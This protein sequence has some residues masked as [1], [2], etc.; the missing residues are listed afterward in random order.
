M[1]SNHYGRVKDL[2]RKIFL[3]TLLLLSFAA[4]PAHAGDV[5][6]KNDSSYYEISTAAQLQWF[7]SQVN[8][9]N[10]SIN[11]VLTADIDLSS[12]EG[13]YWTPIGDGVDDADIV[14]KGVFDGN[15]HVVSGLTVRPSLGSGL[16]G[17]VNG[18]TIRNLVISHPVLSQTS[19]EISRT[20]SF[21]GSLCG[22]AINTTI[23]NCHVSDAVLVPNSNYSGRPLEGVG[24]LCG[25]LSGGKMYKCTA[26]G[27][28]ES[29]GS[30]AGGIAALVHVSQVDSCKLLNTTK[31]VSRVYAK[32]YA[33][34]I[35]GMVRWRSAEV[36]LPGCT[37]DNG[38]V[39]ADDASTSGKIYGYEEFNANQLVTYD[40]YV[41]IY[42]ADHLKTFANW[43]NNGIVGNK[44]RLMRDINMAAA[45]GFTPIGT[46]SKP[47]DGVFDGQGHTIDS[48]TINN[49]DYAG[50]FG[51]VKNGKVK[52]LNLTNPSLTTNDEEYLGFIAGRLTQ[53]SGL[54]STEGIIENCHVTGG[55]LL[56]GGDGEPK[57]VAGI[58]GKTDM[59]AAVSD[60]SFQGIIKAHED[61]IGGI[62]G[63]MNSGSTI[64]RSYLIGPSTVWGNNYVGGI[65]GIMEDTDTKMTDCFADQSSGEITLHAESGNYSGML[66][67]KDN[68]GTSGSNNTYTEE[69]LQYKLT[70]RQ[71]SVEGGTAHETKITGVASSG[72]GTYC[73]IVDIG[74]SKKYFTTEIENVNG[75]EELYFW[76][77]NSNI[78]GTEACGWINMKIDDYAF[79]RNFKRL[80]MVYRIFAGDDHDVMLRPG[81]VRPAGDKMFAN[82]P[83]AKVYVDAEYYD[84]FC[85][86]SVWSKYKKYLV[87]TTSMRRE[88]VNAEYGARYAYDRNRDKTGTIV[89][90]DNGSY[91]GSSQVHV[92]GADD[93]YLNSNDNVLWIYQDIGQTYDFNTTKV[94]A[95]AFNGKDNIQQVK[96]QEITKSA[97]GAS[98]PFHI[99]I[100]DSAFANCKNLTA[101]NI[102][103]YSDEDADHVEFL[104][105]SQIPVGKGVFDNS[106]KAKVMV[107]RD[108]VDEFRYDTQYGWAQYKNIIEA[109]D[110]GNNNYTEDGVIYSYFT[111]EDGQ[112]YYTNANN[113][114]MEKIVAS[115]TNMYANFSPGKVLEYN[116]S[117]TIKYMLASGIDAAKIDKL[118]GVMKLYCDIGETYPNHYKT[119]ALSANGFQYQTS[120]KKIVF[121]DIV[122]NNYN[123]VTDLNFVIPD[124][125][126]RGCS[127]LK[128]LNMFYYVTRGENNYD[129][130]K[131]SQVFIGK[132]VFDGVDK[133]FRIVVMPEYY[134]DYIT[135]PNWSQYKDYIIAADYLPTDAEPVKVEGVTYDY[136]SRSLNTMS[137]SEITRLQNSAWNWLIPG[138]ILASV[139]SGGTFGAVVACTSWLDTFM[140][141]AMVSK[142][143]FMNMT[144][145][146]ASVA[147][148]AVAGATDALTSTAKNYLLNRAQR[149]YSRPATWK[150][151]AT[152]IRTEQTTNVPNMYI[153][154]VDDSKSSIFIFNDPGEYSKDYRTVGIGRTAF[155]NKKN[156]QYIYFQDRYGADSESL[157][158]M[159]LSLP[160][161]CFAGCTNL[162][163]INFVIHSTG[164][165]FTRKNGLTPD[166]FIPYGDIFAGL[167]KSK[168]TIRVSREA[169]PE[170]MADDYWKQYKDMYEVVDVEERQKQDEWKCKY[171]LAFNNNTI[172][173]RTQSQGHDIEHVYIYGPGSGLAKT[174]LAALINDFGEWNNYKLDFVKSKAFYGNSD[175]KTLDITDTHSNIADVYTDFDISL[176]DS[177]FADCKNFEDFNI[178]YQVTDGDNHTE[179]IKPSQITLGNGVF[180]GCDKLRLKFCLDQEEAFLADTTWA[181]YRDKFRPCFFEP[182]DNAVGDILLDSYR[183]ATDLNSASSFGHVDA[184]RANPEDLKTLFRGTNIGTFDEFRAFSSCGLKT[185]YNSMFFGCSSLQS[186]LLPDSITTI[187][188]DAFRGCVQL[189]QLT[190]PA[191][192]TS[193]QA[194]AFA[195][196]GIKEFFVKNPVPADIDAAKAFSDLYESY[197]IYVADSVVDKYKAKW[198]A[199]ADHING[200]GQRRSLKVVTVS[201]PGTLAKEL[202]LSYNYSESIFSDNSLYGNYAQ[203]DSLRVIGTL[204][205]R[206]I[207]VLRYLGG[208]DVDD[209][210]KTPGHL[211]Y[212]DLYEAN[213]TSEGH[214]EYN[215]AYLDNDRPI[216]HSGWSNN[217]IENDNEVSAFMFWGLDQLKTLILPKTATDIKAGAFEHCT[218]LELL[219]IGDDMKKIATKYNQNY[220]ALSTPNKVALVMLG[221]SAPEASE[222]AFFAGTGRHV[223]ILNGSVVDYSEDNSRF[224]LT[225][226]P[227]KS[228]EGY[229]S[230]VPYSS[231]S[232]SIVCNFE[233]DELVKALKV[234]HV[235]S[236]FDLLQ[237]SDITG[238]FN[239]NKGIRKFND[240]YYS[241][242][243][244]LGDNTLTGMAGLTEVSLPVALKKITAKAFDGCTSLQR[245][246]AFGVMIPE[247]E[248]GAFNSLPT[249]FVIMVP[250]GQEDA[251]RKAWPQ[252]KNHIQGYRE[253]T[254]NIR[255]ITLT[256]PN[257]LADSLNAKITMDDNMVI[258]V[259]GDLSNIQAL[260]ISGPIGGKDIAV[261]RYL[262]GREPDWNNIVYVTNLR[263]LDLYDAELRADQYYFMLK[264]INRRIE[265]DN[266]VPKDMFWNCDHLETLILPRTATKLCYEACYDMASLK[267]LVIGDDVTYIDND[268][269]GDNRKLQDIIFLCSSKPELDGDAFTDPLEG[270]KRKVDKIYVRQSLV[271][272][273]SRDDE[274]TSHTNQI[275]NGFGDLEYFRAFGSK[276]IATEDDLP[277]ITCIDGW[278]DNFPGVTSLKMLNKSSI[279]SLGKDGVSK[280]KNLQQI[281]LP[282]TLVRIGDGAFRNSA[283]LHWLD[284][285]DCDSLKSSVDQMEV[286]P[287]A[288]VYIPQSFGESNKANVVFGNEGARQCA[289]YNL[290]DSHDYDVPKAFTAQKVNF[291]REYKKGEY[292][293]LT[294]PFNADKKPSGFTFYGL[295]TDSTSNGRLYFGLS[296]AIEANVPYVV[297]ARRQRT[298]VFNGET[299]IPV[300]PER[301]ISV[302]GNGYTM[303]G[304][305]QTIAANVANEQKIM[306]M[307]DSTRWN[308]V[309]A[310][311]ADLQPFT[312]YIIANS[313]AVSV[314][315]VP[316]EFE[317]MH[318]SVGDNKFDL[319]GD[320]TEEDPFFSHNLDLRDGHD[321]RS[322]TPFY[323]DRARYRRSAKAPWGTLC[324]PY[325]IETASNTDC[326][327]YEIT[328]QS[329]NQVTLAKLTGTIEAG[330]SIVLHM[331]TNADSLEISSVGEEIYVT[332]IPDNAP[333]G[334]MLG[335]FEETMAPRGSYVIADSKFTLADNLASD[336]AKVGAFH[337]YV[338][339]EAIGSTAAELNIVVDDTPSAID[340]LND[341]AGDPSTEYYD[342]EGH[343][344]DGLRKGVN[345]IKNGNRTFKVVIK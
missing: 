54:T 248:E 253:T 111:S 315:N 239:G 9:K 106:A 172:P 136:V 276:A 109:G 219:V 334:I 21:V 5:P 277:G 298:L 210:C 40:G 139:A 183:F 212:L 102:A 296:S 278:F 140:E 124:N 51:Y 237:T 214:Y 17:Y 288:L 120:I 100:G 159:I 271:Y 153:S 325:A 71:L 335:T 131:P 266:E 135:D 196:S 66:C 269:L 174:G 1:D 78:A 242:V 103:L 157:N 98:E 263:Y 123:T 63:E 182:R 88:D 122:A 255:E 74:T 8:G 152:W 209:N 272:Q 216:M 56:R 47:F 181:K 93:S 97:D 82:C 265:N 28:I 168:I 308:V 333:N 113:E 38:K 70:G 79:D 307:D 224:K 84:E 311:S 90:V 137:T 116:N 85:N 193:I 150:M 114:E 256:K 331:L 199:V 45:G 119:I 34:G 312:S 204:D 202:G 18:A 13:D 121:E 231:T 39:S 217:Y 274:F 229:S 336:A 241:A 290:T 46:E 260:K 246:Y 287:Q 132:N 262:A 108:L 146:T 138:A 190:I 227:Y 200:L 99:A 328:G 81:D 2:R 91:N 295:D 96:F 145:Q 185:I 107:P 73:A 10:A 310:D 178:I 316:S 294:L 180:D 57:F 254:L 156:L 225:V 110:F 112:T 257:T 329:E 222:K 59:G 340:R 69:N 292:S 30:Y 29:L 76:D 247:L 144:L 12:L 117:S 236:P 208:R 289:E 305:L 19:L 48:L 67:G 245:I 339:A 127:N 341:F 94:W 154:D 104:H 299:Q 20:N 44:A 187:E 313:S 171:S 332:N 87:P 280:M 65:V 32:K 342:T 243:T 33:G 41:E 14:F 322:E 166:N 320:G 326:E 62:I 134:N 141:A 252:Y 318:Y 26:S 258:A 317:C 306:A 55:N 221:N 164:N 95:S 176:L 234:Q 92:I 319:E 207:G 186:I 16:F 195:N 167:D 50:L 52:N 173:L 232:D 142:L 128:E 58:V 314:D 324:L 264:G 184:T 297:K 43:V 213:L 147:A 60:C 101:F 281:A 291:G 235:F 327:F 233:D 250:E 61:Y 149:F 11:G 344:L 218:N 80:K 115:W 302:R 15:N 165:G 337:G 345:I 77:N 25:Y 240:L 215:R 129:G 230:Q 3:L 249:N 259:G 338:P 194:N 179:S 118:D 162:K 303:H 64:T 177:A 22:T 206:D 205:G 188:S 143:I 89:T 126:F 6:T 191:K 323:T 301:T 270:D 4:F 189:R 105:P 170:F 309:A 163:Y 267:R 160:D 223:G 284:L 68:S 151:Y 273:Y 155:H 27:Y 343:R 275:T 161:S 158:G 192:V 42:T 49:Q 201:E 220:V 31:G 37:N 133:A 198:A 238:F 321:F 283:N 293:T 279:T 53:S 282:S 130:I 125:T 72:K 83:D 285:S 175:L 169:Y 268:A 203:F 24:G 23:Q 300:T 148:I 35:T 286:S 226:V 244:T 304:N 36:S 75:V 330:R 197:V 7:A 251:Y 261:L 211:Q 228:I 86:D